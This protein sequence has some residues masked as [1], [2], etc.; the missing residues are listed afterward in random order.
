VIDSANVDKN[1]VEEIDWFLFSY[2]NSVNPPE[3]IEE[4]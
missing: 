1:S 2:P 4:F 3:A